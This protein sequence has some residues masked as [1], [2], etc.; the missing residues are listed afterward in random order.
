[1][2]ADTLKE[3]SESSVCK[4][5]LLQPSETLLLAPCSDTVTKKDDKFIKEALFQYISDTKAKI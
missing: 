5:K 3:I 4:K 2:L 1:M